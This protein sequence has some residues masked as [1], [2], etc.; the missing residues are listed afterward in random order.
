MTLELESILTSR[1]RCL[2]WRRR[3]LRPRFKSHCRTSLRASNRWNLSWWARQLERRTEKKNKQRTHVKFESTS[4]KYSFHDCWNVAMPKI[5]K[6]LKFHEF[7]RQDSP[8]QSRRSK[9]ARARVEELMES[10]KSMLTSEV[11]LPSSTWSQFS[12]EKWTKLPNSFENVWETKL[13][14]LVTS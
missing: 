14:S 5:P 7:S 2:L 11:W 1:S 10:L 8:R 13:M 3:P 12:W 6:V 9:E 4:G